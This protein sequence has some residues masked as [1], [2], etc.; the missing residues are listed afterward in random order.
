VALRLS[1]MYQTILQESSLV[2]W[3][4]ATQTQIRSTAENDF[5]VLVYSIAISNIAQEL[6]DPATAAD[7]GFTN[8]TSGRQLEENTALQVF[9]DLAMSYTPQSNSSIPALSDMF[10]DAFNTEQERS[11]Y[12][13]EL[14]SNDEIFAPVRLI[15]VLVNGDATAAP[16]PAPTGDKTQTSENGGASSIGVFV[17]LGGGVA[18]IAVAI[19]G[20]IVYY[21]RK[22][23]GGGSKKEVKTNGETPSDND[24]EEEYGGPMS[25]NPQQ[26]WTNEIVV[27]PSADDVS[28]LGGSVLLGGLH[29]D[30]GGGGNTG[31]D[32]PTASVNLDYDFNRNQYRSDVEDRSRTVATDGTGRFTHFSKLGMNGESMFNDMDDQSFERLYADIDE[33]DDGGAAQR[34]SSDIASRVKPFEVRAP[35]GKLGMVVDTPNGGVPVVRA[36]KSDSVL[37]GSVQVGDRL[38]SVDHRDVT[39]MNALEVSSLISLKQHQTRL[40]IFCRLSP[41]TP[42][43]QSQPSPVATNS[44]AS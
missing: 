36:I 25:P 8:G 27:D 42:N 20:M 40:L 2:R 35:P 24:E 15:E 41:P 1:P 18:L 30:H 28:T 7:L 43:S 21:R 17:A 16:V 12:L 34:L 14:V 13:I 10:H 33:D 38:I 5:N 37:S 29:L 32:E 23:A 4:N 31:E 11:N 26:R 19:A 9:F 39:N 22:H 44:T 3:Q 6:V